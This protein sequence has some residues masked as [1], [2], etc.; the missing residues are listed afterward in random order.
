ML[1]V[2]DVL[3][4]VTIC[5]VSIGWSASTMTASQLWSSAFAGVK[6]MLMLFRETESTVSA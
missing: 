5:V 3:V 6:L 2:C 1:K 4:S